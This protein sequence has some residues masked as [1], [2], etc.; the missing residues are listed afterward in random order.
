MT[1]I[2]LVR[3][4][5]VEGIDPERF[6]GRQNL[7]LTAEGI[8]QA[9]RLGHRI[10]SRWSPSAV[11][12]SPL[13]RCVAT[14]AAIAR[15]SNVLA[16]SFAEFNDL[17]YG[18]W[19]NLT[20]AEAQGREPELFTNWFEAP[21]S[22]CF[23]NGESLYDVAARTTRALRNLLIRH[24]DDETI[25]IVGHDSVNRVILTQ[26]LEMPLSAYWRLI[27]QPCC[28]NEIQVKTRTTR[29]RSMNDV[30]HLEDR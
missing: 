7:A 11:Y 13:D 12:T 9:E 4:G 2:L 20:Y 25:V 17:D 30:S 28:I 3:H 21:A 19:Q 22:V 15:A 10:A 18:S 24:D 5:H 6:R 8:Q 27:Q 29:L 26:L 23:P 16:N 14:G 1:T